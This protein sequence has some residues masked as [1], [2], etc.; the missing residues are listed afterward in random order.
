LPKIPGAISAVP[1][2]A[3]LTRPRLEGA[4]ARER[5]FDRLDACSRFPVVWVIGPPGAGK[6][7]LASTY[8]AARKTKHLWIQ[9]DA[10]DAD[11]ASFFFYLRGACESAGL[12]RKSLPPLLTRE[13]LGDVL[14]FARR[15]FRGLF[16]DFRSALTLVLDNYQE[17]ANASLLHRALAEACEEVPEGSHLLAL[18]RLDP[19]QEYARLVA[20]ERLARIE[21][22]DLKLTR[23]EAFAFAGSRGVL[24]DEAIERLHRNSG[25]WAAGF[26]LL[27]ERLA[28]TGLVDEIH[29][30]EG[31]QTVFDY[32]AA[33]ALR[34]M[35]VENRQLLM[36]TSLM[37]RFSAAMAVVVTGNRSAPQVLQ[38]LHQHNLFTDR[39]S[40]GKEAVYQYHAL[41][42]SY[43][44]S[45]AK[46]RLA[47]DE[48]A[49]VT[50][51]SARALEDN[52]QAEEAV[53]LLIEAGEHDR[54]APAVLR[55]APTMVATGRAQVFLG[56]M[57]ALPETVRGA[58]PWLDYWQGQALMGPRLGEARAAFEK[59]HAGFSATHDRTGQALAVVGV[60]ETY[61]HELD[62][63]GP[64]HAW[65]DKLPAL[66]EPE[67]EF[68]SPDVAALAYQALLAVLFW[69]RP[70]LPLMHTV[71][72]RLE[73]LLLAPL[74]PPTRILSAGQ[75]ADFYALTGSFARAGEV[76]RDASGMLEHEAVTPFVRAL[77]YVRTAWQ[78]LFNADLD[79]LE[80][81]LEQ[82]FA[83]CRENGFEFLVPWIFVMRAEIA[84]VRGDEEAL[85]V[86]IEWQ[87]RAAS[88]SKQGAWSYHYSLSKLCALRSEWPTALA[89]AREARRL[90]QDLG[91]T[92]AWVHFALTEALL[93][94][95]LGDLD[96][97]AHT[98]AQVKRA[99]PID[100]V[101]ITKTV[102]EMIACIIVQA[103]GDDGW[104][105]P[106]VELLGRVRESKLIGG[107][108]PT[109]T[110][111][112]CRMALELGV[113]EPVKAMVRATG[114]VPCGFQGVE[115]PWLTRL[116]ALGTF[117]VH[118]DNQPLKFN[119]KVPKKPLELLQAIVAF[120]GVNVST[121][122]LCNAL[123]PDAEADAA[124]VSLRVTLG[125]LRKL[126]GDADL[127]QLRDGKLSLDKRRCYV[128]VWALE[129]RLD[130][131]ER[132]TGVRVN[133]SRADSE[134]VKKLSERLLALYAGP[135]LRDER[136]QS[137]M[138]PMREK[139]KG[140]F[141]RAVT[142]LGERFERDGH[143][144]EALTLYERALAHE[145]TS[146][147]I[148]RRVMVIQ[149][150]EGRRSEAITTYRRCREMLSIVLGIPPDAETESLHR[151]A[152]AG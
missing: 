66:F 15:A 82:A 104:R 3:K 127:V 145:P 13:Y 102:C 70:D 61:L 38:R 47:P 9:T 147:R 42:R 76:I 37:P 152:R 110:T 106:I 121:E 86:T 67:P 137:W 114:F 142:A 108:H 33:E 136:E 20:T 12:A 134:T 31:L 39:R 58:S 16:S 32:F 10:A 41:F 146:E 138:L 80:A 117:A 132:S 69:I 59:A 118:R 18:S 124:I 126:L 115:L 44:K 112:L 99:Y 89:H 57:S 125:R 26:T 36:E 6:T 95:E 133:G 148:Y 113:V 90:A 17:I 68:P 120:G 91:V 51:R 71:A 84:F 65:F 107:V 111:R 64:A 151:A 144:E 22:E 74:G 116:N 72:G 130:E 29:T 129:A 109:L 128:D 1:A 7:T 135:F 143:L 140:R 5:L 79:L 52:G 88:R 25:G 150:A 14:G 24:S 123:W 73:H 53:E 81:D 43:L 60:L 19:P 23:E 85:R 98:V 48:L 141:I 35:S 4:V 77:W 75:L 46:Q 105:E 103:R 11:P 97:A 94:I 87:R 55:L 96:A 27:R 93:Q 149:L 63:F 54:A 28:R 56:W 45:E 34:D 50:E 122:A 131:I 101:P 8:L 92:V 21:W 49:D 139:L 30:S 2:L 83:I 62:D 119:G 100:S 40:G 78:R